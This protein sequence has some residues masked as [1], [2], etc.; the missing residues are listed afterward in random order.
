MI[1]KPKIAA[2]FSVFGAMEFLMSNGI[3][4]SGAVKK[5]FCT[6]E[7][8]KPNEKNS[9]N[10]MQELPATAICLVRPL[11]LRMA[12]R[13]I[14]RGAQIYVPQKNRKMDCVGGKSQ[15]QGVWTGQTTR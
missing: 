6:Y 9:V 8:R 10:H 1:F 13:P 15:Y 7:W 11:L 4:Y 12:H 14:F 3:A 2:F 5:S